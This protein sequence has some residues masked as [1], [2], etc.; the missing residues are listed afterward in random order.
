M[1]TGVFTMYNRNRPSGGPGRNQSGYPNQTGY[2]QGTKSFS[3]GHSEAAAEVASA[4]KVKNFRK[5]IEALGEEQLAVR[6]DLTL[7]RVKEMGEGINLSNEMAYH[8]ESTL[9]LQSGFIDQVNPQLTP[10]DVTRLKT[11]PPESKH[12]D[13]VYEAPR[14]VVSKPQPTVVA[15]VAPA[16]SAATA[17]A[18]ELPPVSVTKNSQETSKMSDDTLPQIDPTLEGEARQREVRRINLLL[19]TNRAGAKT[20]LG[21]LTGLSAANVSHRLHGN[22]IFDFGS[23]QFLAEKLALPLDWFETPQTEET[24]PQQT[25]KMLTDKN[26]VPIQGTSVPMPARRGRGP[27]KKAIPT[28]IPT[29]LAPPKYEAMTQVALAPAT[30][31]KPADEQPAAQ[32]APVAPTVAAAPV[33]AP[34][35]PQAA[36]PIAKVVT[37]EIL[38][39]PAANR[40]KPSHN[41]SGAVLALTQALMLRAQEGKL[42]DEQ[43]LNMLVRLASE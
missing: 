35:A 41:V 43:A 36:A 32:A 26:S 24:I 37:P 15:P 21:R 6:L 42:S 19:L 20:Q 31:A 23:G 40:L 14:L 10:E 11:S 8:I 17:A 25:I 4:L 3:R 27:A 38:Q 5:L 22:K 2:P 18:V 7:Q 33:A 39:T 30:T 28:A 1:R 29:N 9:G 13:A 12:E 34:A 16:V